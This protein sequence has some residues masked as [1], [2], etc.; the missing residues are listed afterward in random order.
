MYMQELSTN[1]ALIALM[2]KYATHNLLLV[3]M[4]NF[5]QST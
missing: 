2:E 3:T 5:L 4:V 1:A